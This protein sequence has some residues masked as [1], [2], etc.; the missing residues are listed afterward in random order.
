MKKLTAVALVL[1]VGIMVGAIALYA[2]DAYTAHSEWSEELTELHET[3]NHLEG[4][5]EQASSRYMDCLKE[6]TEDIDSENLDREET[7]GAVAG[8]VL[9]SRYRDIED[10]AAE[11]IQEITE[12][13]DRVEDEQLTRI[14]LPWR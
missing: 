1:F 3:K 2:Y 13:I 9:C 8:V 12:T 14:L 11:R 4:T 6:V 5:R 7:M 10:E